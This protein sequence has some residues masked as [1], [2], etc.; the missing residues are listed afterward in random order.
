MVFDVSAYLAIDVAMLAKPPNRKRALEY[1]TASGAVPITIIE[2]DGF[3]E[4]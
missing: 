4:T 1:L 3:G 2:R